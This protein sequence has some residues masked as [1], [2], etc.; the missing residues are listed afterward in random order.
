MLATTLGVLAACGGDP[1]SDGA[2]KPTT[3]VTD[4][5]VLFVANTD[6]QSITVELHNVLG[7]QLAADFA[8]T[9]V[10]AGIVVSRDDSFAVIDGNKPNP[11][12]ARFFV[13]PTDPSSF[14]S[15]TF[16]VIAGGLTRTVPVRITPANLPGTF[17]TTTPNI[18]DTVTLSAAA[19]LKFTPAS[20]LTFGSIVAIPVGISLDS[21]TFTFLAPAGATGQGTATGMRLSFLESPQTIATTATI[22]VTNTVIIYPGTDDP[23]TAPVITAAGSGISTGI[24]DAA[25]LAGPDLAGDGGIGTANYY[26][27]VVPADGVFNIAVSWDS[28]ADIDLIVCD[29]A[30]CASADFQAATGAQPETGNYTL[31]A[32]T[33]YIE[34]EH[35]AGT[36]PTWFAITVKTE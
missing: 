12:K 1:T 23:T 32:G 3:I 35:F 30:A 13:R 5:S 16:D 21:S 4:P 27:L 14:V 29:D 7:Q 31:A 20:T 22:A 33:Y 8:V 24:I 9:N 15:T 28:D 6:S 10:G 17:S 18:G 2:D 11:T 26:Q 19:P 34:V 36:A 25:T